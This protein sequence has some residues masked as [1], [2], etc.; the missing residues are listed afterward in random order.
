MQNNNS[1]RQEIIDTAR[2]M[3]DSGL[4]PGRSG[5]VSAR[6]EGGFLITPTGVA[7]D[8]LTPDAIVFVDKEGVFV[9]KDGAAPEGQLRPSSEWRFHHDI[10]R[11]FAETGGV[12]HCHSRHATALACAGR[13]IPAFHYMVAAAGGDEI[14]LAPYALF[15]TQELGDH[16][17]ASMKDVRGVLLEHHGQLATG[18]SLAAAYELAQEIEELAAQYV[19][20]LTLGSRRILSKAQMREVLQRFKTYGVQPDEEG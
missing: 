6:V 20:T 3:S 1:L 2:R 16:I 15:G 7:Y 11:R 9:D 14:P 8:E 12:V 10:Y 17:I 19:L 13:A 5:N 4:S 18:A